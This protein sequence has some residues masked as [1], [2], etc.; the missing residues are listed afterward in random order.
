MRKIAVTLIMWSLMSC[1][2]GDQ[3]DAETSAQHPL[4]QHE[5]N[6]RLK[7]LA[8]NKGST[9]AN[10]LTRRY[11]DTQKNCGSDSKPSFLCSGINLRGT[12]SGVGYNTWD[13]SPLAEK[14]GGVSFTY[15]RSDYKVKRVAMNHVH[16]FILYPE[17]NRPPGTIEIQTLCFFPRDGDSDHREDRGCGKNNQFPEVSRPCIAQGIKT[18]EQWRDHFNSY[19]WRKGCSFDVANTAENRAA[20]NFYEGMRGGTLASPAAFDAPNDLKHKVWSQNIPNSLPIEAFFHL[21]KNANGLE[22]AKNDQKRFYDLTEIVIPIIAMT[23]PA[24][25]ADEAKFEYIENDQAIHLPERSSP[26]PVI[27]GITGNELNLETLVSGATIRVDSWPDIAL[28]Q[29]VWL[30]LEGTNTDGTPYNATLWQSPGSSTNSTWIRD[31]FYTK[32]VSYSSLK[33]LKEGSSLHV[34]FKAV[35]GSS[36]DER[37]AVSFPVRTYTIRTLSTPKVKETYGENGDHLKIDDIYNSDYITVEVPQYTGMDYGHTIRLRWGGRINYDSEIAPVTTIGPLSFR[38]P[39][40]EIIDAIGSTVKVGYT[41]RRTQPSGP[42]ERSRILNLKVDPQAIDLPAP[43]ISIDKTQITIRY[44]DMLTGHKARVRWLG[45]VK[46]DTADQQ[47]QTGVGAVFQIPSLWVTENSGKTVLINYS[48]LRNV[49]GE[50]RLFS[51]VL[52][53]QL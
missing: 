47:V 40:M 9:V 5:P 45:V 4:D 21:G 11:Y 13:P 3:Y 25:L 31:G 30:R 50:R 33:N 51:R 7:R 20:P 44:P 29:A 39:R 27:N 8:E 26:I 41:V 2:R 16:G 28:N 53:V 35:V 19:G 22:L 15:L 23:L 18:G 6:Q 14:V 42:I 32:A 38:V 43:Q 12:G 1:A 10:E 46:R 36:K 48:V 52:R 49:N 37:A 34:T 17:F 24:T